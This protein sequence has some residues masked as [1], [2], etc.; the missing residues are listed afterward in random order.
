M[1]SPADHFDCETVSL[2]G[3]VCDQAWLEL[4]NK[5]KLEEE[6]LR[7]SVAFRVLDAVNYGERN[8]EVLKSIA[9]RTLEA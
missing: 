1:L 3:R 6:H 7:S 4:R 8:P 5:G 9:L 2:M